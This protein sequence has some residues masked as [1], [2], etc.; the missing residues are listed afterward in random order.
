[1]VSTITVRPIRWWQVST[2]V[3]RPIRWWKVWKSGLVGPRRSL[4]HSLVCFPFW[5]FFYVRTDPCLNIAPVLLTYYHLLHIV[6]SN[7]EDKPPFWCANPAV[8]GSNPGS[9]IMIFAFSLIKITLQICYSN[10]QTVACARAFLIIRLVDTNGGFE[11]YFTAVIIVGSL[12]SYFCPWLVIK[13]PRVI[14]FEC[15]WTEM[16]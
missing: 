6:G 7:V 2:I 9:D 12:L 13:W 11:T 5:S 10:A 16:K 8:L 3:F 14:P 15:T 1:M 4:S